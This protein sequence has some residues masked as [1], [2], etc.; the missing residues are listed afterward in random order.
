MKNQKSS[1]DSRPLLQDRQTVRLGILLAAVLSFHFVL[2]ACA[3]PKAQVVSVQPVPNRICYTL[4]KSFGFYL[5]T[6][7]RMDPSNQELDFQGHHFFV[8]VL[9][10]I[11][12]SNIMSAAVDIQP[13]PSSGDVSTGELLSLVPRTP[14]LTQESRQVLVFRVMEPA[15]A[16]MS[17][18]TFQ[19]KGDF[20]LIKSENETLAAIPITH[21][22]DHENFI[23]VPA[24]GQT[25]AFDQICGR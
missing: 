13:V 5:A 12:T 23:W 9:P 8:G 16:A 18:A 15:R 20:V 19:H 11:A 2:S 4:K 10:I 24:A 14:S 21:Q 17:G 1:N 3:T 6:L 7:K 25:P 22:V